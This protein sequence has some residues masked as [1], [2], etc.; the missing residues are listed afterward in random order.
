M[1]SKYAVIG[2][3]P[4]LTHTAIHVLLDHG[5]DAVDSAAYSIKGEL[6]RYP[7]AL[8][9][10]KFMRD[11][12]IARITAACKTAPPFPLV[13]IEGYAYGSKFSREQMGELGGLYRLAAFD[14]GLEV[15]IVPP[16]SLKKYVTGKGVSE[17]DG[18]RMHCLKKWG[19]ESTNNDD[20]DAYALMRLGLGFLRWRDGGAASKADIEV[21]GK[22]EVIDPLKQAA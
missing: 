18:V 7:H 13:V 21:F 3:D 1:P 22:I 15:A 2:V 12:F 9:R 11:A 10:L 6:K 17:K 16:T 14:A 8:A 5:V 19:Y 4:S 20:A